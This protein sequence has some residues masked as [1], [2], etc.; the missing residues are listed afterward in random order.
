MEL[1]RREFLKL[2]R[3]SAISLGVSQLYV[4][5]IVEA[6]EQAAA[7]KPKVLWLAGASCSGCI[8]SLANTAHPRIAE[9]LLKVISLQYQSTIMAAS[10]KLAMDNLYKI[11]DEAK[12][13]YFLLVE[14][15]IPTKDEGIYCTI[16]ERDDREITMLEAVKELGAKSKAIIAIGACA[17]FG[18]IPSGK[19]NPTDAKPVKDVLEAKVPIINLPGC[20]PHPDWMVGTIVHVLLY[21]LPDLD[22]YGRPKIFFSDTIHQ[23]CTNFSYFNNG[24]LAKKF[25]EKGCFIQ[26]GCKGPMTNS[27]CPLRR[28]NSGVN[29]CVGSGATCIGCCNTNFPDDV[30]PLYAAL[31]KELWPAQEKGLA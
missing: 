30:S 29:W 11:A 27:D 15:S 2:C 5:K 6:L 20:P 26:L 14:G 1:T 8:V 23:N 31:P 25:G 28:W 12:G 17:S 9:V 18:G 7:G 22:N 16:G 4:P 19:P 10:G 3:A 13:D 24:E 21:G